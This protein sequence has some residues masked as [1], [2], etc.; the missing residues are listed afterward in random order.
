[1][2]THITLQRKRR[3]W[4]VILAI[5]AMLVMG[6]CTAGVQQAVPASENTPTVNESTAP[7]HATQTMPPAITITARDFAFDMPDEIPRWATIWATAT[8]PRSS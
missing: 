8:T 1:M 3:P 2:L 7:T 4:T 6:A 5:V